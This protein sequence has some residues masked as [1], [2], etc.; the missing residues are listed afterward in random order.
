MKHPRSRAERRAV[1]FGWISRRR[2][3]A[4]HVW[5]DYNP[6]PYEHRQ[7]ACPWTP[8]QWGR[9]AKW[10]LNCGCKGCH[11]EKYF[12]EKRKRRRSLDLAIIQN[13]LE[14]GMRQTG[15]LTI[16]CSTL[17]DFSETRYLHSDKLEKEGLWP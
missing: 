10:N 1:R 13:L 15:K 6:K 5:H 12:K 7:L 14:W 8:F 16:P 17:E 2:Y 9:W 3:I 11:S 4:E